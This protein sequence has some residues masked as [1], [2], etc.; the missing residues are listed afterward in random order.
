MLHFAIQESLET[1][2]YSI[3]RNEKRL[4]M[5]IAHS[6]L[7]GNSHTAEQHIQQIQAAKERLEWFEP[8]LPLVEA[9]EAFLVELPSTSQ[10]QFVQQQWKATLGQIGDLTVPQ[11][12]IQQLASRCD[13][14][15]LGW[16]F[17]A[18]TFTQMK[19]LRALEY[20]SSTLENCFQS[21]FIHYEDLWR[22]FFELN[23]PATEDSI[24][25]SIHKIAQIQIQVMEV[26]V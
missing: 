2:R 4:P 7:E 22:N 19:H 1:L 18:E 24:K 14:L 9:V 10:H 13:L 26:E 8:H 11:S 20:E 21:F 15:Y 3:Q 12:V 6:Y 17:I 23:N 25:N 16:S 5:A